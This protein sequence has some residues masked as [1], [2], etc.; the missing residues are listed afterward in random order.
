MFRKIKRNKISDSRG[1]FV[2]VLDGFEKDLQEKVGEF[3]ITVANPEKFKGGHYHNLANE[4]FTLIS[5]KCKVEL[6]EIDKSKLHE[7]NLDE[8][9]IVTLFIPSRIAHRFINTGKKDF[10][11]L[12]YSDQRYEPTDTIPFDFDNI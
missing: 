9:E 4:W 1:F 6:F 11:L 3:Y 10:I 7:I 5:G 8:N 2:K 12:A